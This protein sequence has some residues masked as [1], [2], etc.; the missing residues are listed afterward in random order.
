MGNRQ[1]VIAIAPESPYGTPGSYLPQLVYD[2]EIKPDGKS[3]N[4]PIDGMLAGKSRA[5]VVGMRN[6]PFSFRMELRG[7]S[8]DLTAG[9]KALIQ[10][11]LEGCSFAFTW[12]VGT[13]DWRGI[14][15]ANEN[16]SFALRANYDGCQWILL[17]C[18]AS[19]RMVFVPGERG[20]LYISGFALYASATKTALTLPSYTGDVAP[21]VVKKLGFVP[22]IY[23][24]E[25]TAA[26]DGH[27]KRIEL[28]GAVQN[29]LDVSATL[30]DEGIGRVL[31]SGP[32]TEDDQGVRIL[33]DVQQPTGVADCNAWDLAYDNRTLMAASSIHLGTTPATAG[34]DITINLARTE[35]VKPPQPVKLGQ[36]WGRRIEGRILLSDGATTE[37]AIQVILT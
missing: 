36:R 30:G 3:Y 24:G 21:I 6:I 8:L 20:W 13:T 19:W 26:Q 4:R 29:E 5:D 33:I 14:L 17:G 27:I 32:G 23:S 18:R 10:D 1:R 22:S 34:N 12:T 16:K 2:F 31:Q 11:V 9:V 7:N 25:P 35:I 15:T 37:D 28:D